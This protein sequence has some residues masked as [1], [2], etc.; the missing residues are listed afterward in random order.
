MNLT[1]PH[2]CRLSTFALGVLSWQLVVPVHTESHVL[3]YGYGYH[4]YAVNKGAPII[5]VSFH[6]RMLHSLLNHIV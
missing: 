2:A 6:S 3:V 5:L 1:F 4:S